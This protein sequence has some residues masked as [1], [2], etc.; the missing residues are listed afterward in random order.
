MDKEKP[1]WS[2]KCLTLE[3]IWMIDQDMGRTNARALVPQGSAFWSYLDLQAFNLCVLRGLG[4]V[5]P[6]LWVSVSYIH[7]ANTPMWWLLVT[8]QITAGTCFLLLLYW[9]TK[10]L[11]VL[12]SF[13]EII[14]Y[15]ISEQLLTG[16]LQNH[17]YH[18]EFQIM[19]N[20]IIFQAIPQLKDS[21]YSRLL[22]P[23]QYLS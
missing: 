22:N 2:V 21:N 19:L 12:V 17:T 20:N 13:S 14:I 5:A 1:R 11:V 10:E 16:K 6:Y 4:L 7:L 15:S 8:F 18:C 9:L 23:I 3:P